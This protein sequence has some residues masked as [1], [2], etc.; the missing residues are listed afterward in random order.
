[1]PV[2]DRLSV[3]FWGEVRTHGVPTTGEDMRCAVQRKN[4]AQR[5]AS[6]EYL[7]PHYKH[8]DVDVAGLLA[9]VRARALTDEEVYTL[10]VQ[11][12]HDKFAA[13]CHAATDELEDLVE[14]ALNAV[15]VRVLGAQTTTHKARA[16][17]VLQEVSGGNSQV[18]N[19]RHSYTRTPVQVP[20]RKRA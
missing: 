10:E 7:M 11:A 2:N 16:T 17:P 15:V 14:V 1:M 3:P 4:A 18:G 12:W 5:A 8:Q 20:D 9:L 13:S 19:S 6:K